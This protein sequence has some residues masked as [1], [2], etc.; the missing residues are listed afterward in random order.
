MRALLYNPGQAGLFSGQPPAGLELIPVERAALE[1]SATRLA[2]N[3]QLPV[4][5]AGPADSA[6]LR[7]LRSLGFTG[8]VLVLMPGVS[9]L[10]T[11]DLIYAGADDVLALPVAGCE[12]MARV[13]AVSRRLHG[14]SAGALTVGALEFYL[15]G[16]HPRLH[17]EEIRLSAREY[18]IMRHLML[19]AQRVVAKEAIYDA[20]YALCALPPFDKIIDV[21]IC[22]LRAKMTRIR[23]GC[24]AYIETVPGR[25]YRMTVPALQAA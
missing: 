24:G 1:A 6:M 4:F 23:P 22:R 7:Q 9:A 20:L 15:D 11:A 10:Q 3:D 13:A 8:P 18:D 14:V 5:L 2:R 25:G 12:L 17:G 21:Y 16:R 19:N